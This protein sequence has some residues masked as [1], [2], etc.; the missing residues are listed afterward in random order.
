MRKRA[1]ATQNAQLTDS[2]LLT[3]FDHAL[4]AS[5]GSCGPA[6]AAR[7]ALQLLGWEAGALEG[8]SA[9]ALKLP[10]CW[11]CELPA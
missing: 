1:V 3:P 2:Q 5:R 9:L 4:H 6:C 11:R 10:A 8:S 7:Q